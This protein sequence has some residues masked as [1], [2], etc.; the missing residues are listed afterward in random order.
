MK[1]VNHVSSASKKPITNRFLICLI[2]FMPWY[3][4]AYAENSVRLSEAVER[5]LKGHP[6]IAVWSYRQ[7][8]IQAEIEAAGSR[9]PAQLELSVEDAFGTDQYEGTDAMQ[10]TLSARWLL[11]GDQ[12]SAR[13]EPVSYTHLTLPTILLV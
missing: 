8:G 1:L 6:Q 3:E 9:Q 13:T 5:A 7:Q 10:T 4:S 12:I 2:L 11:E